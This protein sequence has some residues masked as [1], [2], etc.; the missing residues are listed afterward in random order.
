MNTKLYIK[1]FEVVKGFLF[2]ILVF[3]SPA[4]HSQCTNGSIRPADNFTYTLWSPRCLNGTDGEIRLSNISSTEGT[5]DFTNQ[6]YQVRILS[7][8]G[9]ARNFSVALNTSTHTI[10]G[11]SAGTYVVD[12]IDACGGNSADRTIVVPNGLNNMTVVSTAITHIDRRTDL[13]STVCGDVLKFRIKTFSGTT[14]GNVTYSF[15]NTLGQSLSIVNVVPQAAISN[16]RNFQVDFE[17]PLAFFN[18]SDI[19]YTAFNDCGPV[20]GGSLSVPS[21]REFFFDTPEISTFPDP[22]NPCFIGYDVKLFRNNLVNPI[23]LQVEDV[24]RPGE[25]VIDIY[26]NPILGQYVNL[27]HKKA[28]WP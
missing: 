27:S 2:F 25:P 14:S 4:S 8:P 20:R 19:T 10:S 28:L 13:Y 18:D 22:N 21:V 7:G 6:A 1:W 16:P 24:A 17:L 23:Y 12:I 5:N 11:L 9:G 15:T 26:G 3:F